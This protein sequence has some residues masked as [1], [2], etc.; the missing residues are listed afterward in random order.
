MM[1]RHAGCFL[2][3]LQRPLASELNGFFHDLL[4]LLIETRGRLLKLSFD[5]FLLLPGESF[6]FLIRQIIEPPRGRQ[7]ARDLKRSRFP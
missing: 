6:G 5:S 3:H 4:V 1:L 7:I 2:I